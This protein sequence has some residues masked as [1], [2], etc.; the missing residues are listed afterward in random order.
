[1]SP[2]APQHSDPY[3]INFFLQAAGTPLF[4]RRDIAEQLGRLGQ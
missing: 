1:M 4:G 2:D 3:R